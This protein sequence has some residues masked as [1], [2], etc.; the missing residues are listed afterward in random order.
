MHPQPHVHVQ[1]RQSGR[2]RNSHKPVTANNSVIFEGLRHGLVGI[3]QDPRGPADEGQIE[4]HKPNGK[5]D[6][7]YRGLEAT[8]EQGGGAHGR[9]VR[10]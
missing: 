5:Q 1:T 7:G 6:E 9:N 10:H 4:N 2:E 8:G 3:D